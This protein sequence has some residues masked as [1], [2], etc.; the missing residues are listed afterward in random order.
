MYLMYLLDLFIYLI[1]LVI[2]LF[3]FMYLFIYCIAW[4]LLPTVRFHCI[5]ADL[6]QQICSCLAQAA[7][8]QVGYRGQQVQ[9]LDLEWFR[10]IRNT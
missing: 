9:Y 3:M 5:Q 6:S 2:Y 8:L 10:A 1:N 7:R 4:Y